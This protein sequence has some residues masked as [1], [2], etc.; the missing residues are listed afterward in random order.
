ME[1]IFKICCVAG[2]GASLF[3]VSACNEAQPPVPK[4]TKQG[5]VVS[6][7]ISK[8]NPSTPQISVSGG[9]G[10][11]HASVSD[12]KPAQDVVKINHIGK[13]VS[14]AA[15]LQKS[16]ISTPMAQYDSKDRV[17][18]FIPLVAEKKASAVADPSGKLK[19][20]RI[21][22]PL[23]KLGLSQVKLV[24]V[25]EMQGRTIAMVEEAGGKG[26]EVR[27]GTYIGPNGGRVTSI[28]RKG[29]TIEE[30]VKDFRGKRRKRYEEIKFHKSEDEE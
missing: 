26:Y 14:I 29:I 25:V 2:L 9:A 20:K 8:L 19:P 13:D 10:K 27:V 22:T 16:G 6:K 24:A 1:K 4:Q 21:L 18:P 15:S 11:K 28:T 12:L 5:Q 30:E 17:D 23:E 7:P 3:L